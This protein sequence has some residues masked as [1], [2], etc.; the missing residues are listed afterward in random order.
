MARALA[1]IANCR[2]A[3][4]NAVLCRNTRLLYI[5]NVREERCM[6]SPLVLVIEVLVFIVVLVVILKLLGVL[7]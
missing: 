6:Q 4:C 2:K 5:R 7:L 1:A 3:H